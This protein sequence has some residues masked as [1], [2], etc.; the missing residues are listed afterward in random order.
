MTDLRPFP[1]VFATNHP[2]RGE[3]VAHEINRLLRGLPDSLAAPA[4]LA[5]ATAY[6]N[7]QGF[8]LIAD[9]VEIV[10]GFGSS[11]APN[12]TNRSVDA[13]SVGRTS[14]STQ[15]PRLTTR[16]SKLTATCSASH[17]RPTQRRDGWWR[18]SDQQ[19]QTEARV[20]V[21]RHTKGFLHGKAFIAEH[22]KLPAVLA[23]SSN[24]T[25]AG[26]SLNRELNL[27]YPSGQYTELVIDWF[28]E[29][30]DDS[31]E[32]FDLAALYEERW[33]P[34]SPWIVFLRMLLEMYGLEGDDGDERIGLP[35]TGFQRD[36]IR[37]SI[38]ILNELNGV[39]VCDEVGLG[40]TFIAG[41]V[42]RMVL[43]STI[44]R[45]CSSSYRRPCGIRRG[46]PSSAATSTSRVA[47][48]S[49]PTTSSDSASTAP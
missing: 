41:E 3:T 2:G 7:P 36:G 4:D 39:L 17:S 38:R 40:K 30:W 5:M 35:V 16:A 23:G 1:P 19:N 11:W 22:G 8:G 14:R 32:P 10:L 18:G 48:R 24:L 13:S 33:Q 44:A 31:S 37:R 45:R 15:S 26:L 27:G 12:R 20:E 47:S 42:I 25:L 43:L 6:I 9:E 28:D 34:H 29:L 46:C 49:S 21:R